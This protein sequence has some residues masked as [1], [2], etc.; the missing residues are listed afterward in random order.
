M[1]NL[2]FKQMRVAKNYTQLELSRVIG[3][4]PEQI[5]RL[6]NGHNNVKKMHEIAIRGVPKNDKR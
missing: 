6:E 5:S 4:N 1:T 2:E 3:I